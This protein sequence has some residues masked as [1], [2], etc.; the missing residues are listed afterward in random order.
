MM[1]NSAQHLG[2]F[3]S[4]IS[5]QDGMT[6]VCIW[7]QSQ[8][9]KIRQTNA[10]TTMLNK[11]RASHGAQ[12]SLTTMSFTKASRQDSIMTP[13]SWRWHVRTGTK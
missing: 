4:A 5:P 2:G 12:D 6:L 9:G 13:I 10:G 3:G 7:L 11:A 1:E 8:E